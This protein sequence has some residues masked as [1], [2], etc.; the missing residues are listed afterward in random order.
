MR[1]RGTCARVLDADSL[2]I[3][4]VTPVTSLS[5]V[6]RR[7]YVYDFLRTRGPAGL[8]IDV[9]AAS[10]EITAR[11]ATD[12]AQVVAFE[13]F[14][15]NARLF[16]K[17]LA[18]HRNVRLIEKAVSNRCGRTTFF[19]DS[20][21]QGDEPGWDDQIGY[22]SVGRIGTSAAAALNNYIVVGL[23]AL[24]RRRGA[25]LLRVKTTTLDDELSGQVIDFLKV[26]V[27]GAERLVLEGAKS[28]LKSQ[29]IRLM[30]LEWSGDNEV[31]RRLHEAGYS[32]FDSVYVGAG[33]RGARQHFENSGFEVIES[34]Q[35]STGQDALEMIYRGS[36][37]DIGSV[38]RALNGNGQW[39]Q[40]DLIALPSVDARE[41]VKFLQTA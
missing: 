5:Y 30:Y 9:G 1:Q 41:F 33:P 23:A 37:S 29:L 4:P 11:L 14:P 36:S 31:E 8:Y 17:R 26:D 18:D 20:T 19:V 15:S 22:S 3:V 40:T 27:Q 13:P 12:A 38:L 34:I 7:D 2:K 21:V 25:T 32:V 10:G 16:R 28:A 39:I 6:P 35:L 24:Q